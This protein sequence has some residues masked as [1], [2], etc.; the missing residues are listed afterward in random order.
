MLKIVQF[1]TLK[2]AANAYKKTANELHGNYAR[3]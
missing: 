2:E 1:D 3:F